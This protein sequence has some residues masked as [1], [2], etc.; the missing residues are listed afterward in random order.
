MKREREPESLGDRK[1]F[2]VVVAETL[3]HRGSRCLGGKGSGSRDSRA[4]QC[5]ESE[6]PEDCP[7]QLELR[8][9]FWAF[10]TRGAQRLPANSRYGWFAHEPEWRT[11]CR[12]A[13][14]SL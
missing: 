2:I 14:G 5:Q 13:S 10:A 8:A 6:G 12:R 1:R 11:D 9:G 3:V 4:R 7:E